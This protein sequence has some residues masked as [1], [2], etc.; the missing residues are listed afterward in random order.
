MITS[1]KHTTER[2]PSPWLLVRSLVRPHR[3]R[4]A[5]LSLSSFAG[6]AVEAVFLVVVTR[7]ALAI[8]DGRESTGLLAGKTLTVG[9]AIALAACLLIARLALALVGVAT[10]ASLSADVSS[11]LR[12]RLADAYL[13][14]SWAVQEAEPT[15]RLSQLLTGFVGSAVS[16]VTSFTSS[17]SASLSL[18][19]LMVVATAVDPVSTLAVVGALAVLGSVLAPIRRRIRERSREAADAQMRFATSVSEL[20]T[21]GLEMQT[22]GVRERFA[23]RIGELIDAEAHAR[24]RSD[25]L[26]GALSPVYT[27]LAYGALITG[28]GLAALVGVGEL[29]ALGA[30][31]L[32]MLRSLSYGQQLQVASGGLMASLPFLEQ[33]DT[34]VESY[35]SERATSG[36][37]EVDHI[38][39][40]EA[41]A[42]SFSYH[43]DRPVLTDINF[44]IRPGEVVGVIGPS[45]AGKSTLVQLL[46]GLRDPTDG[47]VT[48]SGTDLRRV[49]RETWTQLV[50][51]VAQDALMFTGTV[52]ENIRFCRLGIEDDELH[53]ASVQANVAHDIESMA[54]GFDTHLGERGANLSG[55][56]RQ[57]LSIARAL[58]GRPQ[59]LI[60][61]EPTSSLDAQSEA[62]V[63]LAIAGLKGEVTVVVIAHRLSTLEMCDRIMVIEGG[64][65]MAFDTPAALR[66]RSEFYRTALELSG[67]A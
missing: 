61:D 3:G 1:P 60:L 10:S 48:V 4:V 29:S 32:V 64:R 51:F 37:V 31:M 46:L 66:Q 18:V 45:G 53:R 25:V 15:G 44:E 17:V 65:L 22:Y 12:H 52:A 42:V 54:K 40:I 43:P 63:R 49:A 27:T 55:G 38:G 14:A 9:G 39:A 26:R 67:I 30:V 7:T 11:S 36:D 5:A 16:A 2:E 20:G 59:L 8:A 21:L 19:A 47:A 13:N 28:L 23:E 41:K 62:L 58:V 57:R 33:L 6:G 24:R 50:A 56:Q 35:T 34:T